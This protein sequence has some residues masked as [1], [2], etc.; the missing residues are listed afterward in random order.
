VNALA[1]PAVLRVVPMMIGHLD[2]VVAIEAQAYPFPWSRGNFVDSLAAGYFA[3]VMLDPVG[4]PVAYQ[5]AMLGVDEFHLLNLT[6]APARWGHGHGRQLLDRLCVHSRAEHAGSVWLEVRESN[7]RARRI[8]LRYGFGQVGVR[9]GYYP[10]AQGTR[11][12]AIVMSLTLRQ[13]GSAP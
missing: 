13:P 1:H 11:E 6:V 9:R 4:R 10:A 3:E 7:E 8:Y 12:D 5:V 2:A